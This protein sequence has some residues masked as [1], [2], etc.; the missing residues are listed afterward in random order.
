[1][2]RYLK[3]MA[4]ALLLAFGVLAL[5]PVVL[6]QNQSLPP[7]GP[8]A[9]AERKVKLSDLIARTLAASRVPEVFADLRNG[10]EQLYLPV[11]REMLGD[12]AR[13][14]LEPETAERLTV[15]VPLLDYGLRALRELDPNTAAYR[16]AFLGD[17]VNLFA[18]H[19]SDQEIRSASEL[20]GTAAMRKGF[21]AFYAFSRLLTGYDQDDIRS[22]MKLSAWMKGLKLKLEGSPHLAPDAAPPPREKVL[23]A[24]AIVADFV[25]VS[26]VE[27]MI[28]DILAFM[29]NVVLNV[30]SL[31][32][33]Q[34][35]AVRGAVEKFEFFYGLGMSTATAMVPSGLAIALSDEQLEQFGTMVNSAV[36]AKSFNLLRSF[37]GEATSFTVQDLTELQRSFEEVEAARADHP[38][39]A[40]GMARLKA[41]WEALIASW[42][43]RLLYSLTPDTRQGLEK[44]FA[45]F[46]ALAEREEQE[47]QQND[48]PFGPPRQRPGLVPL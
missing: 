26:Q 23:K 33:D 39:S 9:L 27:G 20:L 45:E 12:P 36:M 16:D 37:V 1:M 32:M 35:T 21:N 46:R 31:D 48:A 34:K 22:S 43:E 24:E 28:A 14:D 2:P 5:P 18:E 7:A 19:I 4:A 25:R 42:R 40:E 30:Q 13:A 3:I 47:K 44:A 15:L 29:R 41:G 10:V 38:H 8:Q 17:I 11:L 6:S